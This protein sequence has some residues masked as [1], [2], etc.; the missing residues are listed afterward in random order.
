[1]KIVFTPVKKP[2][3][4]M[5]VIPISIVLILMYLFEAPSWFVTTMGVV[6]WVTYAI[7]LSALLLVHFHLDFKSISS[8]PTNFWRGY[9]YR[10]VLG[11]IFTWLI[12]SLFGTAMA[13]V[14]VSV[15]VLSLAFTWRWRKAQFDRVDMT[16]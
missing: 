13:A 1:M 4:N 3:E 8:P 6:M 10:I 2:N 9:A 5:F 11:T 16:K 15:L 12:Y 14:H 7:I